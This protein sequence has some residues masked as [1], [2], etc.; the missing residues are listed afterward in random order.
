MPPD[1]SADSK[2]T[3]SVALLWIIYTEPNSSQVW[4]FA[5]ELLLVWDQDCATLEWIALFSLLS[6]SLS[7]KDQIHS[8]DEL[9]IL[10]LKSIENAA[11]LFSTIHLPATRAPISLGVQEDVSLFYTSHCH[12]VLLDKCLVCRG[13]TWPI[14]SH[15]WKVTGLNFQETVVFTGKK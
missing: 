11:C 6:N 5:S 2:L 7:D 15:T 14:S 9:D 3:N 8:D 12:F 1:T 4:Q 13:V 10:S